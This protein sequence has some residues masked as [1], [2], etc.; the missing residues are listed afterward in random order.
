MDTKYGPC[1]GMTRLERYERALKWNLNPPPEIGKFLKKC[2]VDEECLWH[3]RTLV[4]FPTVRPITFESDADSCLYADVL[5]IRR[6]AMYQNYMEQIPILTSRGS[7]I[8]STLWM[9]LGKSIKKLYTQPLHYLTNIILK[10]LDN[11]IHRQA[12]SHF[13]LANLWKMD[14]LYNNGFVDSIFPT[15]QHKS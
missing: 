8:P 14:P 3:D 9:G 5:I 15:L 2:N 7:V 11:I 6:A 12:S 13:H 10:R 4:H 1:F